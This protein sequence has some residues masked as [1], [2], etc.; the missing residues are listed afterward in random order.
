MILN[1]EFE[2]KMRANIVA[3]AKELDASDVGFAVF[4]NSRC[5]E[6]MWTRTNDGGF[7]LKQGVLPSDGITDIFK[8]G[9]LYAFE[10]ATAM[11]IILYKATLMTIAKDI[12]NEYFDA[13]FIRDWQYDSDLRLVIINHQNEAIPGDIVYFRNRD[14][15][16]ESPQWQGENAVLLGDN[17]YFGHGI[18]IRTAEQMIESL[19]RTRIP[20]SQTSAF[21]TEEVVHPDFEYIRNLTYRGS[22]KYH[23]T[24][25]LKEIIIAKIGTTVYEESYIP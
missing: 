15:A 23:T 6:Q 4:R 13:L 7:K 25:Y 14:H 24:A 17:Q 2:F 20:G 19:N 3:S 22:V 9:H 12:F 18:G 16:P 11:V 21:L 8:N 1:T 5:N 10:C